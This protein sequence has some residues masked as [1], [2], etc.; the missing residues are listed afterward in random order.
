MAKKPNILFIMPD[1]L[2]ADFLSCYGAKFIETPNID[3]LC[4][5]GVLYRNAYSPSPLCVPARA[6]LLTG[7]NAV[8][9]GILDN[10]HWLRP[11]LS[12]CGIKTWPE[13]L[14]EAGYFTAA[15]GKM[16]F[17]PWDLKHGFQHKVV[18]ED[19]RWLQIEDDYHE[20]LK[21][22]GYR[23][24][25]GNEHEGY[26]DN[27]GAIVSRLPWEFSWDHFVGMEAS[28][29]IRE[30]DKEEPFAAMVGFPGPHC[31]YDPCQ[32]FL[33]QIDVDA[34]PD[35][36]PEV[37]G[38]TAK[39]RQSGVESN[40]QPWN[41]VDYTVFTEAQKR[42]VRH[43]YA[44]LVKQIDHE[45][46]E[47]L[48]ALRESGR[49]ENTAIIFCSDH[50]DHLGDHN[51]IGKG[52]FYES[53]TK[54]PLI[55]RGVGGGEGKVQEGVASIEDI[56]ATLLSLGGCEVPAYADSMPLPGLGIPEE[57]NR[58]RVI[59]LLNGGWMCFDGEWK[60]VK[61]ASE[62]SLLFNIKDDPQ[63]QH[64]RIDDPACAEI[65]RRLDGELAREVM[66]SVTAGHSDLVVAHTAL[67]DE[68][69][70]GQPGWRRT[71][72]QGTKDR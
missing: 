61:Y 35:S 32:E 54:V 19:K 72:P 60:L 29:F 57:G 49:L 5:G 21:A 12:E 67:Y 20:Y 71:Y 38:Q 64:N 13:M 24:L 30:Y 58:T 47:I 10:N 44:A 3:S 63:E 9:N 2:R 8:K 56:T 62:G 55:A 22:N 23:K 26:Q 45:V 69:G 18:C 40:K 16:H 59:G 46:G 31:P 50:G 34:I 15:I 48:K 36:I 6:M 68:E 1:Q 51:L 70:F 17:Y 25:H 39:M 4:E 42:K 41:G 52:N 14:S 37:E 7:R 33:D 65:A 53:S 43:H 27:R 28:R 11:D 66:R